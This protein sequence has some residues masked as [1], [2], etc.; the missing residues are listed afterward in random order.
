MT[1]IR[2]AVLALALFLPDRDACAAGPAFSEDFDGDGAKWNLQSSPGWGIAEGV[3]RS[4]AP[5]E[6][7]S[8]AKDQLRG[9]ALIE[10]RFRPSPQGRP[11]VGLAL[12]VT[13]RSH[14]IVR[15]YDRSQTIEALQFDGPRFKQLGRHGAPVLL[16]PN[17]WHRFK[18]AIVGKHLLAKLWLEGESEPD[19][20]LALQLPKAPHGKYGVVAHDGAVVDFDWVRTHD[21]ENSLADARA[22]IGRSKQEYQANVADRLELAATVSEFADAHNGKPTRTIRIVPHIAADRFPIAGELTLDFNGS[23]QKRSIA[24]DDYVQG[25]I[26]MI[27]P[28]PTVASDAKI[29]FKAEGIERATKLTISPAQ[30]HSHRDYV[31]QCLD[32][33]LDHGRDAYGP[34]QSPLFMTIVDAD[35]LA[36]PNQPMLLDA[37]VRLEEGR[38]HRRGERGSNLWY[39][40]SLMRSLRRMSALTGD[41]RYATA[42]EDATR[43][44]FDHCQKANDASSPYRNGLPAWGT[45]VYWDC[46]AERPAGD[47]EGA[48]PHEILVFDADW[49]NMHRVHPRGV[50]RAIDG[51]WQYHVF[52][53][54][55]GLFNRHDDAQRGCD[56]AFSGGSFIKAFAFL[57]SVTKDPQYLHQAKTVAGWHWNHRDPQT[58]LAP[59]SPGL[60]DRYDGHHSFTTVAGPHATSLLEAYRLTKDPYFRDAAITY[61]KAY[62]KYGWDEKKQTYW[63]MLR[64]DGTPL[65]ERPKGSGYDAFAP[66]GVVDAWRT[67][68]YSYEF[69]LSAGQAAVQAYET[70]VADG[71]PDP[72]LLAIAERWAKVIEKS[73]PVNAGR[74]WSK[75]LVQAVPEAAYAPGGYAE[76]YGRAISLFVHLYRATNEEHYLKLAEQLAEEATTKL[77][78]NGMFVGHP[79][80]PYYETTN[81]VGLLLF[82][83]LELDAPKEPIG[84]AY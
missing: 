33:L 68:M 78:R 70:T 5:T 35:L 14:L 18:T 30:R 10:A 55:T 47:Q 42:A 77:F 75:E 63:A 20:Q 48:G 58:G 15:Y 62:D 28:E 67:T 6:Q 45:H 64:L 27:V 54:E 12:G 81:G 59:D 13:P 36:S 72:E 19:W 73:L 43:Y 56:F 49:E 16:R 60:T 2:V 65:P 25:A 39:D 22:A 71:K 17:E 51:I 41:E 46:Y 32:T 8:L 21:D 66:Y 83:L 9:D 31:R 74:R 76:D 37:V 57:Y 34:L 50:Q 4:N 3:L 80:K 69:T 53:K 7:P 23:Q 11:T 38:L 84:A 40:Q 1:R 52:D 26:V 82:A 29:T 44:F 79:A 61:I 24:L